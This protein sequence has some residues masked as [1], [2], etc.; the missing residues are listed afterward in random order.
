MVTVTAGTSRGVRRRARVALAAAAL[1]CPLAVPVLLPAAASAET[2]PTS[3]SVTVEGEGGSS[4]SVPVPD[5]VRLR[6]LTATLSVAGTAPASVRLTVDGH[7]VA[8]VRAKDGA[9]V[10]LPAST[11]DIEDGYVTVGVIVGDDVCGDSDSEVSLSDFT[12]SYSGRPTVPRTVGDFFSDAVTDVQ[13]VIP[14]DATDDVVEAGLAA[15][16]AV[17]DRYRGDTDVTMVLGGATKAGPLVRLVML[18]SADSLS[19]SVR[20]SGE[21][22]V[23]EI[24]GQDQDLADAAAALDSDGLALG[25]TGAVTALSDQASGAT[26]ASA[27]AAADGE[28]VPLADLG[29]EDITLD[30]SGTASSY[31]VVR[32]DVFGGSVDGLDL[33]LTGVHTAVPSDVDARVDAYLNGHLVGSQAL[34]EDTGLTLDLHADGD[35]LRGD[36]ALELRLV[37]TCSASG[38]PIDVEISGS[39]STVSATRG[40]GDLGALASWPQ[41]APGALAVAVGSAAS[42]TPDAAV[43]AATLLVALQRASTDQIVPELVDASDLEDGS[44]SGLLVGA[45]EDDS[46][47]LDAGLSLSDLRV[48][49]TGSGS[50]ALASS[51]PFAALQSVRVGSHDVLVLGG[52]EPDNADGDDVALMHTVAAWVGRK[53][54]SEVTGTY[55][56]ANDAGTVA[57]LAADTATPQEAVIDRTGSSVW[58]LVLGGAALALLLALGWV[59]RRRQRV[60]LARLVHAQQ[61]YDATGPSQA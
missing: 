5:G 33:H 26:T 55:V 8:R 39:D 4:T 18:D 40:T 50:F 34:G 29:I 13:V 20:T 28:D 24:D 25:G 47:A 21:T 30:G 19:A 10:R 17:A 31:D 6:G 35:D 59:A 11:S 48:L 38:L 15:V 1:A 56:V 36:N 7:Q 60:A 58:W 51:S 44:R 52:W 14:S 49:D 27:T 32:Q 12:L 61:A 16:A 3:G 2:T 57:Q 43:D 22:P 45:G 37:S 46:D 23:L 53:G 9:T 42:S 41:V 54:W